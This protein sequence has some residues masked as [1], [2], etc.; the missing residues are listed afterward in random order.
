VPDTGDGVPDTG[1][2][3]PPLG[4]GPGEPRVPIGLGA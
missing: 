3:V 1:D 4:P 2:G